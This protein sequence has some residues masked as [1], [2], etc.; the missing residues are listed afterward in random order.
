MVVHNQIHVVHNRN[1]K[2]FMLLH[3]NQDQQD[4]QDKEQ[5]I[6]HGKHTKELNKSYDNK[7]NNK[8]N[9]NKNNNNSENS[10]S[11]SN[12]N[13]NSTSSNFDKK[14]IDENTLRIL[15]NRRVV[16]EVVIVQARPYLAHSLNI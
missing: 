2:K 16:I 7:N 4:N 11:N 10:N 5:D 9:N 14:T 13:R 1:K 6:K 8:N 12:R 15:K 3:L